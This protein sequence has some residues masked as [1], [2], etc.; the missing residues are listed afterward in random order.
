MNILSK[1]K[2]KIF[3]KLT[4]IILNKINTNKFEIIDHKKPLAKLVSTMARTGAGTDECLNNGALPLPIDFYSPVPDINDLERRNIWEK[5]S[6]LNG[7]NF[8]ID[9]QLK[10]LKELGK[11][12][13]D[14]CSWSYSN[15]DP[16]KFNLDNSLPFSFGCAAYTHSIIRK[17]KPKKIIEFG[18]GNSSKVIASAIEK[19]KIENNINCNYIIIDPFP[20]E[21]IKNNSVKSITKLYEEKA[22]NVKINLFKDLKKD[23]ILFIDS[24][25]MVRT[26]SDVN[27]A[28]LDILP[29][30]DKGVIIQFHDIPIPYEYNKVYFTNPNFRVFWTESYLLQAFLI[31][32][33]KVE[34]IAALKFLMTEQI[35]LFSK[36]FKH[37]NSF[38]HKLISESFWMRIK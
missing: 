19:N 28:I 30:L 12:F 1:I 26:G 23:D 27:Y 31:N 9:F 13:S 33:N 10:F 37:Y 8:N 7:I 11:E 3:Y 35:D 32:N 21:L 38:K 22:E 5:K 25:H 18:S 14:E 17:Y 34:I 4:E 16:S 29:I 36:V 6:D 20:S 24:S 2:A 15:T